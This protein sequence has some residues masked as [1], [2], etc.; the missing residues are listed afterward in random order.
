MIEPRWRQMIA[1]LA[2]MAAISSPQYVWTLFTPALR[3]DFGVGAAALQVAFSLLIILQT[4]FSPIQGWIA[5]HVPPRNLIMAGIVLT[6][7][8]WVA[9][10]QAHSL[11]MLYLTYGVVGGIGTG[12]VYVGVVSLLMQWFPERRGM[13]A[14]AA[15]A[16]YGMGAMLTTFPISHMLAGSGWRGTM[17][18]FGALIAVVGILAAWFLRAPDA[19]PDTAGDAGGYSTAVVVKTPVFWVM[20]F[21]MATMATSGLMVTSQLAQIAGDFKVAHLT[22]AGLAALPLAMTLDRIANGVTR[23]L[24]GWISDLVGRERTMALAFTLEAVA[25][26][27]WLALAHHPVAFVLLSGVVFLGWGEIFSLFPATLTDIFGP[28]DASR[29]YGVLYIAQ[30]VGAVFGGPLAAWLHQASGAWFPV[31]ACAI[32]GDLL[33]ALLA[34]AVLRPMRCRFARRRDGQAPGTP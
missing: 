34:I 20:F 11:A 1:G 12:T 16:G 3:A 32:G 13:A 22:V 19:R 2:C 30:G 29:N 18:A 6:G 17:T 8:S 24:F 27:C 15:A 23:P 28:R 25:L 26:G 5:R 31:F 9:A 21:M 7:L 14:G 33:T 10:A 4:L